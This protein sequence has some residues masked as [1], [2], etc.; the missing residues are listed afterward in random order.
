[1]SRFPEVSVPEFTG[2]LPGQ[3]RSSRGPRGGPA[4]RTARGALLNAVYRAVF[5]RQRSCG[6]CHIFTDSWRGED[7]SCVTRTLRSD[8]GLIA[9]A[10]GCHGLSHGRSTVGDLAV[11]DLRAAGGRRA[12]SVTGMWRGPASPWARLGEGVAGRGG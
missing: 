8:G 3:S 4:P 9:S 2:I 10:F 5:D 1:M 11:V 7:M 6:P 12:Y